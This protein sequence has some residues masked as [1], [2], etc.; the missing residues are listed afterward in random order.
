MQSLHSPGPNKSKG[1]VI[2]RDRFEKYNCEVCEILL[3]EFAE[4]VK[5]RRSRQ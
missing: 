1:G 4:R 3:T 5:K 2:C